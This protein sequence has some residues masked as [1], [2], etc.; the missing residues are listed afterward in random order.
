MNQHSFHTAVQECFDARLDPLDDARVRDYLDAHPEALEAFAA[1]RALLQ[2]MPAVRLPARQPRWPW[3]LLAAG[4][5]AGASLLWPTPAAEAPRGRIL[6]A[7]LT[8]QLAPVGVAVRWQ[9]REVLLHTPN[10]RLE[11]IEQGSSRR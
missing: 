11:V 3:L 6:D 9:T 2:A 4:V 7:S 5:L 1:T 8:E 10:T